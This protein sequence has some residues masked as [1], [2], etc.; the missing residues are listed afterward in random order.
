MMMTRAPDKPD[1]YPKRSEVG[2]YNGI[3]VCKVAL[4]R[5]ITL[6]WRDPKKKKKKPKELFLDECDGGIR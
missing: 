6:Q 2:E 3:E 5:P 1:K 4:H